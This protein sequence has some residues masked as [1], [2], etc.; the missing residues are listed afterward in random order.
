MTSVLSTSWVAEAGL[1][2]LTL[3]AWQEGGF[4]GRRG[5]AVAAPGDERRLGKVQR[6]GRWREVQATG[7]VGFF[8]RSPIRR[9]V[10]QRQTAKRVARLGVVPVTLGLF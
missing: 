6:W 4:N 7:P 3:C 10:Y 2:P 5:H 1:F 8:D 9:G